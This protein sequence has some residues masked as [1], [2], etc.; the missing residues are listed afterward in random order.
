MFLGGLIAVQIRKTAYLWV[1]GGLVEVSERHARLQIR[2]WSSWLCGR[3]DMLLAQWWGRVGLSSC[4]TDEPRLVS[5]VV[6]L[7]GEGF[8]SVQRC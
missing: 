5:V 1:F 8:V 2:D 7:F 6:R 4:C 3:A